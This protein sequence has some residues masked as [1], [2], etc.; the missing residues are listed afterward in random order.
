MT[1]AQ[2]LLA[3]AWL[4]GSADPL[5]ELHVQWAD[6]LKDEDGTEATTAPKSRTEQWNKNLDQTRLHG[7]IR[8]ELRKLVDLSADTLDGGRVALGLKAFHKTLE[9]D[10]LP[11][12]SD[13]KEKK[14]AQ[15][16]ELL[17]VARAAHGLAL[18]FPTIPDQ[19]FS[20]ILGLGKALEVS[21]SGS[22]VR[23]RI[24]AVEDLIT[25]VA[26]YL[27]A[28]A[29]PEAVSK[30]NQVRQSADEGGLLDPEGD[31][32]KRIE[33]FQESLDAFEDGVAPVTRAGKLGWVQK[34]PLAEIREI[35]QLLNQGNDVLNKLYQAAKF[36]VDTWGARDDGG[37]S[38][39]HNAGRR[40]AAGAR[41]LLGTLSGG[42]LD[43]CPACGD[44]QRGPAVCASCVAKQTEEEAPDE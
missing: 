15:I 22:S 44:P 12:Q 39:V 29:A 1:A 17:E 18:K 28:S 33:R 35:R 20:R 21:L 40:V 9:F 2:V 31:V 8:E 14:T 30:W 42:P 36:D 26:G 19:E 16:A 4:R 41:V 3:R 25:K 13:M 38:V 24:N 6:L 34:V 23:H 7:T 11:D 10:T 32:G 27:G 5:S 37:I 43:A